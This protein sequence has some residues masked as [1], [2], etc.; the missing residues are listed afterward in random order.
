M[1]GSDRIETN[2]TL[3]AEKTERRNGSEIES[4]LFF[5]L[6][7]IGVAITVATARHIV[8]FAIGATDAPLSRTIPTKGEGR[9]GNGVEVSRYDFAMPI[10]VI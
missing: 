7:D 1:D 8:P 5:F 3:V 2:D 6:Y 10:W 4:W 9:S